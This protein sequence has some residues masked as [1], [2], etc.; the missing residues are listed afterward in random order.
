MTTPKKPTKPLRVLIVLTYYRPHTSG[1]TIYAER[2]AQ[3]LAA[4]GH[5][6][7]VL[8]SR[9]SRR[10]PRREERKGVHVV[11]APVLFRV[12][13]G[14]IMPTF[15]FLAWKYVK[16]ADVISLHLPQF[17]AAGV[18]LRGRLLRK[19]TLLTYHCDLM[20]PPGMFNRLVNQTVHLMN[21]LAGSFSHGVVAYT[22]DFAQHSPYLQ[23][24]QHK[25]HVIPPPV[26]LPPMTQSGIVAFARMH[27]PEN[28]RPVI[29]MAARLASEKG[30]E[31]LLEALPSI[32]ERYP[33]ALVLFAGQYQNV[34]AEEAYARRLMPRIRQYEER[35]QWKFLGVLDPV[36]MA[37][38]YPNLDVIVVPSLN[39]TESF[40][41]VQVE[42]ML[43]GTPSVASD[44]PGVRQPVLQTGMGE[45]A[46]V[47][48]PQGLA[49][50]ILKVLERHDAYVR[51]REE[52]VRLFSTQRTVQDYE[53]LF[54]HMLSTK[55]QSRGKKN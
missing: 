31:I 48:D 16:Q 4:R 25:L 34:L 9:Y 8:T 39:S 20:L 23:R 6:V 37:A 27:N 50:A 14:V 15:G 42:A 52:I 7:T 1:L 2:L 45:I 55:G 33:D 32:L 19:P 41:L 11:R 30:V 29:G 28:K 22:E 49:Q 3:G 51:P 18:A 40:G 46:P 5:H 10:L 26:E 17:D 24:F 53:A 43:C 12:S 36:Q 21:N 35:G 13:K 44:L 54:Y 38:F 47:G